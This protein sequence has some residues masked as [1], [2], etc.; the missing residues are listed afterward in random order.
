MPAI[1]FNRDN[2]RRDAFERVTLDRVAGD[3]DLQARGW[4]VSALHPQRS[5]CLDDC[6]SIL[7]VGSCE[8]SPLRYVWTK[9]IDNV[10]I[11]AYEPA[12]AAALWRNHHN[13]YRVV[14]ALDIESD[15]GPGSLVASCVCLRR[16]SPKG[17]FERAD[18]AAMKDSLDSF[19]S[20]TRGPGGCRQKAPSI[21]RIRTICGPSS[22]E[23]ERL[24]ERSRRR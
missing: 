24:L 1:R 17:G 11:D 4:R 6:S 20:L 13:E 9:G 15:L 22:N 3:A 18:R 2:K 10:G 5:I 7:G 16:T 14:G 8:S 21:R 23:T 19:R 12:V